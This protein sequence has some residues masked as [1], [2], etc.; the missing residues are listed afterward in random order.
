VELGVHE[1]AL[2][3]T[4]DW[5]RFFGQVR[6]AGFTSVDLSVDESPQRAARLNWSLARRESVREAALRQG[7]RIGGLCLSVHR[8]IAP[9]SS[10]PAVRAW[11]REVLRQGIDLCAHLGVPV[12]Q[13]AGYF[14]HYEPATPKAR[15]RYV[16]CLRG[17][18]Q[19]ASR[20][21]VV[22]GIENVDGDDIFSITAAL[23]VVEEIDSAW[24]ALYPD[25]GNLAEHG[26][27]VVAELSAGRG[28]MVAMHVKD[29]EP[30]KPRRVSMGQGVVP[31]D[32]A[33]AEL[34]RQGWSGRMVV[35]MWND[36]AEDSVRRAWAAR[37]FIEEKLWRA[38]IRV[39]KPTTVRP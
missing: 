34:A 24:L 4:S 23:E 14:A 27:D 25:L 18:A 37:Q 35:E 26:L 31:W 6:E 38:G 36:D 33:F 21:G 19:H 1:K 20:R 30:G 17:G 10:D 3:S 9:G 29:V 16:D 13:L 2:R 8:K 32:E 5:G 28:R 12:L 11:A 7:V 39:W 15:E 22:L